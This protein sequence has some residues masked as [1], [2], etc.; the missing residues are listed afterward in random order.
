M[1]L[2]QPRTVTGILNYVHDENTNVINKNKQRKTLI[3]KK[4]PLYTQTKLIRLI[5][6]K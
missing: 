6:R 4:Q 5:Q 2:I 3:K 1:K